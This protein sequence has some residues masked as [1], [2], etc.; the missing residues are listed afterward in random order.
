M[1]A[2]GVVAVD[3]T[4]TAPLSSPTSTADKTPQT[5]STGAPALLPTSA[6]EARRMVIQVADETADSLRL[7]DKD[8]AQIEEQ[9]RK[10]ADEIEAYDK[11]RQSE[12]LRAGREWLP[13]S[14][15]KYLEMTNRYFDMQGPLYD[16]VEKRNG[17][18][19]S[20]AARA[21][22]LLYVSNPTKFDVIFD[23]TGPRDEIERGLEEFKRLV[24]AG[25]LDGKTIR[26]RPIDPALSTGGRAYA[27]RDGFAIGERGGSA[28][29]IHEMGHVLEYSD[30]A[31]L[32]RSNRFLLQ[33]ARGE[34]AQSLSS[35]VPGGG[36]MPSE[37]AWPD[38]FIHPYMGKVYYG[39]ASEVVSMGLQM[40]YH[41]P[42]RLARDD[43]GYFEFIYNT[44][45]GIE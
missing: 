45:R 14:D 38:E 41:E 36:Y 3:G 20:L 25:S 26:I 7:L 9:S 12:A 35:L 10:M 5:A 17:I 21:R 8:I 33:R 39:E 37:M 22:A 23:Y 30:P 1:T 13:M 40:F 19:A 11:K 18:E 43:P 29:V 27:Q 34:T 24:P 2:D 32:G 15:A 44:L 42:A 31:M 6:A 28:T 4:D 16:L